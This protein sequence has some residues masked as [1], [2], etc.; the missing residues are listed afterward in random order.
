MQ[1]FLVANENKA[2][3]H[4]FL[5]PNFIKFPKAV[6]DKTFLIWNQSKP[7]CKGYTWRFILEMFCATHVNEAYIM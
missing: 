4:V 3:L 5:N 1:F 2:H 6:A 7:F